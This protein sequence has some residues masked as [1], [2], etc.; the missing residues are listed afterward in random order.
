MNRSMHRD[1]MSGLAWGGA[2]V[3]VSIGSTTA[4]RL[5]VVDTD[6]VNRLVIGAS[7]LMI[8]WFG[9]RLPKAVFANARDRSARRVA[10]WAMT[11]S[12]LVFAGLW[13]FAPAPLALSLGV[14]A[15]LAGIAVS[16][17]YCLSTR[18]RPNPA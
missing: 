12:G 18:G 16:F 9:N 8:A 2:I 4:P 13:A 14:A 3:L 7:G 6:T 5:G 11:L 15:V 10:G 17:G 1:V